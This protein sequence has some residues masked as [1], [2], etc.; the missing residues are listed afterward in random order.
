[1]SWVVTAG[2]ADVGICHMEEFETKEEANK[3]FEWCLENYYSATPPNW[4]E[5]L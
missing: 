4:E 3:H 2:S 5:S 1:M